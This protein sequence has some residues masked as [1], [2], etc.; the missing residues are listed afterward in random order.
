MVDSWGRILAIPAFG[1]PHRDL[2]PPTAQEVMGKQRWK[3]GDGRRNAAS[4]SSKPAE[5][6]GRKK[7]GSAIAKAR[8]Q[9]RQAKEHNFPEAA[10][11]ALQTELE[12]L[13][14]EEEE[15]K[16]FGIRLEAARTRVQKAI[17]H[18]ERTQ[19]TMDAAMAKHQ[20]ACDILLDEKTDLETLAR[21]EQPTSHQEPSLASGIGLIG[22]LITQIEQ[23][24]P[25]HSGP[26]SPALVSLLQ[27]AQTFVTKEEREANE[28]TKAEEVEDDGEAEEDAA[29]EFPWEDD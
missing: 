21:K 27:E 2:G 15:R 20:E 9:L 11:A 5:Q 12:Q 18:C 19:A 16:P 26:P 29:D 14:A 1:A 23:T 28:E 24:W 6:A 7:P 4:Y 8:E 3:Q 17:A 10:I 22:R 13:I 25:I